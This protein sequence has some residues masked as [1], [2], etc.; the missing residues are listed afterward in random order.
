[1]TAP[2]S[3]PGVDAAVFTS[4]LEFLY[5]GARG[6]EAFSVLFDGFDGGRQEGESEVNVVDKLRQV[7]GS[8]DSV[9]RRANVT[10]DQDL[11]Y[12]WR[13][14]LFA[15]MHLCVGDTTFATHR[16]ILASRSPYFRS[17]L[18]GNYA[19]STETTFTL[20]SPPFTPASTMFCLGYTYSG[21]LEFGNRNFDLSTAFDIWRCAEYLS[22]SLLRDEIEEKIEAMLNPKRAARIYAFACAPDVN[23]E[24]L[25]QIASPIVVG[26]FGDVW[27]SSQIGNLDFHAQ[28]RLVEEVCKGINAE[29]LTS[30]SKSVFTLRRRLALERSEWAQHIRSMLDA[31]EDRLRD[32]LRL[33]LGEVV[34]T[35]AFVD[36]TAGVGFSTDVLEWVL[37]LVVGG[38]TEATAPGAYQ[39]LVGSVLLR[40]V[41]TT[42]NRR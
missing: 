40:E 28:K 1:V 11:L 29:S 41:S 15:D 42:G 8:E 25:R 39:A 36:L 26:T 4:W 12:C 30:I 21:T 35:A 31:I 33:H 17:V 34:T 19:D 23:S 10:M 22:L 7:S 14:K 9:A 16:A 2:L 37:E 5:T 27:N 3:L 38:L 6:V 20:P 24:H 32:A 13:S 18:L